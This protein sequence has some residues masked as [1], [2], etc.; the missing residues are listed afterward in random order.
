MIE[1]YEEYT[2]AQARLSELGASA[3]TLPEDEAEMHT[4]AEEI[5]AYEQAVGFRPAFEVCDEDSLAWYVGKIADAE[6]RKKRIE[7]QAKAMIADEDRRIEGLQWRYGTQAEA[8]MRE[9][10][11]Q[12]RKGAKSVKLLTGTIGVKKTPGRVKFDGDVQAIPHG[13]FEHVVVQ[14]VDAA[15]LNRRIKVV[16]DTAY[17]VATGEELAVAGLSVT[18]ES[19]KV[20]VK[21]GKE[22]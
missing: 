16:G 13:L 9:L 12:G 17:S 1:S 6:S 4:L 18:P 14:K 21:A 20:Y 7:A 2:N 22:E 15:E 3:F 19:E 8:V 11:T 10:L 5:Q